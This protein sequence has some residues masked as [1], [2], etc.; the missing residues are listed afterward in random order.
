MPERSWR[1]PGRYAEMNPR[2]QAAVLRDAVLAYVEHNGP[3]A[4]SVVQRSIGAPRNDTVQKAIEV[5][6]RTQKVYVDMSLGSRDPI[7]YPNGRLAHP[8]GQR[9]V[10]CFRRRYVIRAY[11]DRLA[12]KTVT[13]TE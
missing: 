4:R 12:G 13:I 9:V 11:D 7:I 6:M 2:E 5:L 8:V 10:E 3:A 1:L